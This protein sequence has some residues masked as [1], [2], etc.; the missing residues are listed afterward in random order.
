FVAV[1]ISMNLIKRPIHILIDENGIR[2]YKNPD[3]NLKWGE[4][5]IIELKIENTALQLRIQ[6]LKYND[7]CKDI[8]IQIQPIQFILDGLQY[9]KKRLKQIYKSI[10]DYS[11]FYNDQIVFK[12]V[13]PTLKRRDFKKIRS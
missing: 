1:K 6:G 3:A 13:L 10:Q 12:E 7:S 11:K 8:E 2:S 4:I 9:K 5:Q